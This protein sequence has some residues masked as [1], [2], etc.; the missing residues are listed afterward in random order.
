MQVSE[1]IIVKFVPIFDMYFCTSV[2]VINK[3][4]LAF[5]KNFLIII[6]F[7]FQNQEETVRRDD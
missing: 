2:T 7:C 1:V 3:Y 6:I 4:Y 5:V